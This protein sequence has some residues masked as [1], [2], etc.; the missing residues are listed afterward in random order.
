[1][2]Y[3]N[4]VV[5]QWK[6]EMDT[7]LVYVSVHIIVGVARVMRLSKAGLF[8]AVLTAFNVQSYPLLQPDPQDSTLAVL[9]EISVQLKSFTV[10]PPFVN[11]SYTG[12][13]LSSPQPSFQA[14]TSAVWLNTL[15]FISLVFSLSSA[16]IALFVKQWLRE[17]TVWGTSR[18]SAR[19]RQYR[20]SALLKWH[21]GTVVVVLPIM[22]QL[23]AV[24]FLVGLL[25]LLWTLHGTV[26]AITSVLVAALCTFF[27]VVTI[28]PVWSGDCPYRSP[29]SNAIHVLVRIIR[30]TTMRVIRYSCQVLH[31]WHAPLVFG[32]PWLARLIA[33][34]R[35]YAY[36]HSS[37]DMPTWRG[38]DRNAISEH[39]GAL[40]RA[41]V[42]MAYT[43]TADTKHLTDMPIIF[44]EL[45]ID[46]IVKCLTDIGDY[47][48]MNFGQDGSEIGVLRDPI[49]GL[50]ML[51]MYALRH[52]LTRADKGS[53]RWR[54]DCF[55]IMQHFY[56]P[57]FITEQYAEMACKTLCQLAMEDPI[58]SLFR[59][60]AYIF[61]V[62]AYG[63]QALHSHSTLCYGT[64]ISQVTPL[65]GLS[66]SPLMFIAS[67]E[68]HGG[69]SPGNVE[70]IGRLEWTE[71]LL[72]RS[73]LRIALYRGI[74]F[75]ALTPLTFAG[76]GYSRLGM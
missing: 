27:L 9:R 20:L 36:R 70:S 23:A 73:P 53:S 62:R 30:N 5:K 40:D 67:S 26:A 4:E 28:L 16:S 54:R 59:N 60:Q 22:L 32:V 14:P 46:E 33:C 10:T 47:R 31:A 19:L 1:M 74:D 11:A 35:Q 58:Y 25:V 69:A 68:S 2:T 76:G 8:S 18:Q 71:A 17:A 39:V 51:V 15:W 29:T 43:T 34:L 63:R 55:S 45:P 13:S 64:S 52:M 57:Q 38:R 21:V 48:K 3:H 50:P 49:L 66:R 37:L 6:E 61:L 44:P 75:R 72:E 24:L 41:M 42:T 56:V 7:L 12:S 65:S